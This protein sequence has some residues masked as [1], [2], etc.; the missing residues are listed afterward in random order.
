MRTCACQCSYAI[1]LLEV[2]LLHFWLVCGKRFL[3]GHVAAKVRTQNLRRDGPPLSLFFFLHFTS[4]CGEFSERKI[5]DE[6]RPSARHLTKLRA[7]P[8]LRGQV[9]LYRSSGGSKG[10]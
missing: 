2:N 10:R 3:F 5:D 9:A 4:K 6:A 1:N 8:R 7:N